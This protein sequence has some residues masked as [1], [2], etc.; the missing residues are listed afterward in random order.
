MQAQP[1][2]ISIGTFWTAAGVLAAV[3]M[4]CCAAASKFI[5][6]TIKAQSAQLHLS[7]KEELDKRLEPV[8]A[9]MSEFRVV[10]SQVSGMEDTLRDLHKY[11]HDNVHRMD[12][13]VS[14]L[15]LAVAMVGEMLAAS[16]TSPAP[17][18]SGL[19]A[20]IRLLSRRQ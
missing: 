2:G 19:L 14:A 11:S 4:G 17:G 13:L 3:V 7:I 10:E 18:L 8:N 16:S 15:V 1:T 5:E 6:S 9:A 12:S 20:E